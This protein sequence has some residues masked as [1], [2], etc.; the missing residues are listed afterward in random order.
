MNRIEYTSRLA[1]RWMAEGAVTGW[2][3]VDG[4]AVLADLTG[5]TRLT[6]SL[7]GHGAEGAEVLHRALTLSFAA[8]LEPSLR[9]GGDII[10]FAGDAALVWFDGVDHETRAADSA[11]A[12]PESLTR[13]PAA[14]TGGKRLRVSVGVHTG[15]ITAILTGGRQRGL[16]LCGPEISHLVALEA[17]AA[18][19]QV[20]ASAW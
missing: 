2:R 19:G 10:G 6:E 18:A 11:L 5:F 15:Q 12:M 3:Q 7:A 14:L 4:T 17:A 8:L 20:M 1:A 16:F 9:A 13:L